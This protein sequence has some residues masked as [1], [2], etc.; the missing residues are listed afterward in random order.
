MA[1]R[2]LTAPNINLVICLFGSFGIALKFTVFF[3]HWVFFPTFPNVL[4]SAF[5]MYSIASMSL[6]Y[7]HTRA[8]L[9]KANRLKIAIIK[10]VTKKMCEKDN[11]R[12]SVYM[13]KIQK[14]MIEELSK[15]RGFS[16]SEMCNYMM[17]NWMDVHFSLRF[18][19]N[20]HEENLK[21]ISKLKS[22]LPKAK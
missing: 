13:P 21:C 10:G 1:K 22:K 11:S 14:T 2:I 17:L 8:K 5:L 18:W 20:E 16:L 7:L 6:L 9:I 3:D 15:Q 12:V 19:S 4:D